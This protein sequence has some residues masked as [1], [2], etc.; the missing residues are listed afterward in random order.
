MGFRIDL[1]LYSAGLEM[2]QT[3]GLCCFTPSVPE[4]FL[5]PKASF[6]FYHIN[7]RDIILCCDD[8]GC[9]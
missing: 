1:I 5:F 3:Q 9:I 7:S 8:D 4:V 6:K 2:L